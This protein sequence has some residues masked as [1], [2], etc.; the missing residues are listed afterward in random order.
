MILVGY[1]Q[2]ELR[3]VMEKTWLRS[4]KYKLEVLDYKHLQTPEDGTLEWIV[5]G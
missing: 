2:T 1:I 5:G 4:N 3:L